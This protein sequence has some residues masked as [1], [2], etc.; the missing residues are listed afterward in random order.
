MVSTELNLLN[1]EFCAHVVQ[2]KTSNDI[3]AQLNGHHTYFTKVARL[4]ASTLSPHKTFGNI[5][6]RTR[7][8]LIGSF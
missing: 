8:N 7:N 4:T 6:S 2:S 3:K 1:G 5:S